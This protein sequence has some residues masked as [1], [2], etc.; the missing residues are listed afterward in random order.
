VLAGIERIY[1]CVEE[2]RTPKTTTAKSKTY[3]PG[4]EMSLTAGLRGGTDQVRGNCGEALGEHQPRRKAVRGK[5]TAYILAG[6]LRES[7]P[8]DR[9]S[10]RAQME[11]CAYERPVV[12]LTPDRNALRSAASKARWT[13]EDLV[14]RKLPTTRREVELSLPSID[15]KQDGM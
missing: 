14:S 2:K 11:E 5:L 3:S 15:S 8:G 13:R 10:T 9:I 12:R 7:W 4:R 6:D 1:G